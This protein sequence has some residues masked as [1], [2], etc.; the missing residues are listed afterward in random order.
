MS[1]EALELTTRP[2]TADDEPAVLR[3]LTAA[4][5]GGP[6]G[7]RSS[8][9]FAWKHRRNP[10]GASPGLVAEHEGAM[11]GVRVFLRWQFTT[12]GHVAQAVRAVDTATHP[13]F[14]GRGVF[15]R[16]TLELLSR[17]EETG[18][19]DLVFNTPNS[20]SRP[21]YLKMGW[22]PVGTLP[23]RLSPVRLVRFARGVRS[24]RGATVSGDGAAGAPAP[25]R[26]C[27]FGPATDLLTGAE[28]ESLV[29]EWAAGRRGTRRLATAADLDYLRWRYSAPGL[30]YRAVSV[31]DAGRLAG[32]AMGRLR[33][34]G[35]LVEFTLGDVVVR[36]GDTK[37]A[38][39]LLRAVR[40][41]GADHVA[42]HLASGSEA[43]LVGWSAGCVTVPRLGIGLVANPRRELPVEPRQAT[44]WQLSLGD[45]EVF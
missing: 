14:Q 13:A 34:R 9:F 6:T 25:A 30:D 3:L 21:G 1:S 35:D 22:S 31:H 23:V 33:T 26:L 43:G 40:R 4:L 20:S 8:E 41:S 17:L 18:E 24:A 5:A 32:L 42:A 37:A 16:L 44:S 7:E 15:R 10:F 29:A 27:P 19:V 45:L 39:R 2:M 11:V 38:R 36:P 28:A 12:T